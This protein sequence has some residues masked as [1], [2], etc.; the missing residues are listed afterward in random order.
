MPPI[1]N[2]GSQ[3]RRSMRRSHGTVVDAGVVVVL[4][5]VMMWLDTWSFEGANGDVC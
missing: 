4:G 1:A 2:K 5:G 3:L